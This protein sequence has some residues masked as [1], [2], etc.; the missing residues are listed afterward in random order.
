MVLLLTSIVYSN[1][2]LSTNQII[3]WGE[4][5]PSGVYFIQVITETENKIIKIIK[6]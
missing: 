3:T 6:N 2:N 1:N 4:S 5:A